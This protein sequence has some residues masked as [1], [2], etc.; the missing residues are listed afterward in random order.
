[1]LSRVLASTCRA[2]DDVHVQKE[3]KN[4]LSRPYSYFM[5]MMGFSLLNID[6]MACSATEHPTRPFHVLPRTNVYNACSYR[7]AHWFLDWRDLIQREPGTYRNLD[8]YYPL[9]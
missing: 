6:N 2:I 4:K 3:S 8:G 5:L 7:K 9:S 1:M